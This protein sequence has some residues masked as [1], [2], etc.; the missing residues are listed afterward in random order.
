[1]IVVVIF[2]AVV[3][4]VHIVS[5]QWEYMLVPAVETLKSRYFW[6]VVGHLLLLGLIYGSSLLCLLS[7]SQNLKRMLTNSLFLSYV[8]FA[9]Q[10]LCILGLYLVGRYTREKNT[11]LSYTCGIVL[12][13]AS[14]WQTINLWY[15]YRVVPGL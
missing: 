10:V 9:L 3:G 12:V 5:Y 14:L 4:L 2:F 1:M 8:A 11:G 15:W 6:T 13:L 7:P